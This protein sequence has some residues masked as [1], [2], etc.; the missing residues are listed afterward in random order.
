MYSSSTLMFGFIPKLSLCIL[1]GSF[2]KIPSEVIS[3][4]EKPMMNDLEAGF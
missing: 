3:A 4:Y 2:L 1:L